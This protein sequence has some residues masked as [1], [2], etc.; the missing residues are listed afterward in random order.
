MNLKRFDEALGQLQTAASMRPSDRMLRAQVAALAQRQEAAQAAARHMGRE[1]ARQVAVMIVDDSPTV[2]KLV[3][4]TMER[5]GH[6]V[7]TAADGYE[8]VDRV[9]EDGVPDL[10]LLD[11]TMPGVDGY[12]LCKFFKQNTTT[13]HTPVVMLSGKD[14]FFSKVRGKMAGSTEYITKPFK[15]E[16]LL[17]LVDKYCRPKGAAKAVS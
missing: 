3:T 4:V 9:R 14:G 1:E 7:I 10:I 11:I 5:Q 12:Q 17:Q 13:A 15:P 2:R 6:R 8:A 16:S